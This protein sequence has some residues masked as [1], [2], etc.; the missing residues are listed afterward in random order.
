MRVSYEAVA[1]ELIAKHRLYCF[2][3]QANPFARALFW[4]CGETIEIEESERI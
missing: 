3:Q 1:G 2:L 4:F